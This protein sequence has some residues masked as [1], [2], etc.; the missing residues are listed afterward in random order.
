MGS[1]LR[2]LALHPEKRQR[3]LDEIQK[4]ESAGN[5]STPVKYEEVREYL[6][7]SVG[8]I[9]EGLRLNPPASN[10]FARVVGKEGKE[11]DGHFIPPDTEITTYAY[12]VGRDP[13][14]YAPDPDTFRPERWLESIEKANEMDAAS[15]VF[16][17]GPRVCLG[18]DIALMELYKLIPE[19]SQKILEQSCSKSVA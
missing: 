15:Y 18:K 14:L 3:V 10:L 9:K 12:V 13:E 4:A 19:V 16:G 5:L 6:P 11:I 17:M 1:T 8:C 7:Y 2:F